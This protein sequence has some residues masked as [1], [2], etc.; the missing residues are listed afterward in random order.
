MSLAISIEIF[1]FVSL[2]NNFFHC[3]SPTNAGGVAIYVSNDI[4]VKLETDY[5]F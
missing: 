5:Q 2:D 3:N 4:D 1:P